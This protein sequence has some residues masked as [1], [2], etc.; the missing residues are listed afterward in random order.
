MFTFGLASR[1]KLCNLN[2]LGEIILSPLVLSLAWYGAPSVGHG[3]NAQDNGV[4]NVYGAFTVDAC[5]AGPNVTCPLV[6]V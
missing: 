4:C 3:S 1:P 2:Q 6:F 5:G